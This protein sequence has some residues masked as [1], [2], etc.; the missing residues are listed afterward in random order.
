MMADVVQI[1]QS[2]VNPVNV[3]LTQMQI[4]RDPVALQLV[5]VVIQMLT[6]NVMAVK[7]SQKVISLEK[8]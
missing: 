5:G 7:I 6:A 1:T 4:I 3:I 2:T 8:N